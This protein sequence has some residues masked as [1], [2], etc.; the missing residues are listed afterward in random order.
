MTTSVLGHTV[1]DVA[2]RVIAVRVVAVFVVAVFV[3]CAELFFFGSSMAAW[4]FA[5]ITS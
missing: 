5:G 4:A 1:H 3:V 2:L